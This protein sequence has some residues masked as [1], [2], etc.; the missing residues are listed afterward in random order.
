MDEAGT[1]AP[2]LDWVDLQV[3]REVG[4][5]GMRAG[6]KRIVECVAVGPVK[7]TFTS[8]ARIRSMHK[9]EKGEVKRRGAESWVCSCARTP[10]DS[11]SLALSSPFL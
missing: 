4:R 8:L 10:F 11:P 1:R 2:T 7:T 5:E 6:G 9:W 3:R